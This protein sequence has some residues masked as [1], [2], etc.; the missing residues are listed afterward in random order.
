MSDI[1][2]LI[3]TRDRPAA[4]AVTLAC[5]VGQTY[6]GFRVLVSD[7]SEERDPFARAELLAVVRVLRLRGQQVE[8]HRHLPRRGLAEHRQFL[9]DQARSRF[10]LFL[11]DDVI[12]EADMLERLRTAILA[13]GCGLVG[14][15]LIGP[16]FA[17]DVRP[18]QQAFEPWQGRV[19]PEL[20]TPRSRAWE[21]RHLHRAANL[22]HAQR[23][24]AIPAGESVRYRLAWASGCVL[25]D[26]ECLRAAGGFGFWRELPPLHA[27][28]DVLAQLRVMARD[29]GCGIMP[30][31]AYHQELPTTVPVRDVDAPLVLPVVPDAE[32]SAA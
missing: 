4:L 7:Q 15:G 30:T 23:G 18:E 16:S 19:Q 22:L 31:G 14:C 13:E 26:T 29:G 32:A 8:L 27:G 9:L 28:E 12:L 24:L 1:D 20:V 11:D 5:L 10:C 21:R 2:V 6:R 3:P 25:Y 17:D